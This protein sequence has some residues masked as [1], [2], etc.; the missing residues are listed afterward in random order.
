[1][2]KV[3]FII[4]WAIAS[5]LLMN[6]S[7]YAVQGGRI[8]ITGLKT[9]CPTGLSLLHSGSKKFCEIKD[10]KIVDVYIES[11]KNK[12]RCP[13]GYVSDIYGDTHWCIKRK[14]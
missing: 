12:S 5:L 3:T 8:E 2:K 11:S 4:V 9:G 1:M 14:K 13:E 10:P 6:F 7:S